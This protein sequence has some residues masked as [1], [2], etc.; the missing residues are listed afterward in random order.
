MKDFEVIIEDMYDAF[1]IT[2]KNGDEEKSFYF[3]QEDSREELK[4][5]FT[6][7]GFK[8]VKYEVVC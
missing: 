7:L 6:F 1:S 2:V 8:N 5:L 3:D 4:S